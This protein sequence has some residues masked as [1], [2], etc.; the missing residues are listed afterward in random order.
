MLGYLQ[1]AAGL[2]ASVAAREETAT[3]LAEAERYLADLRLVQGER[4]AALERLRQA[5]EAA[6]RWRELGARLALLEAAQER[7]KQLGLRRELAASR[8]EVEEQE[9]RSQALG[10]QLVAAAAEAETAREALSTARAAAHAR[11]DALAALNAA[12][13][14]HAQAARYGEHLS[15]EAQTLACERAALP[16]TAPT[17]PAPDLDALHR[18]VQ[19]AREQAEHAEAQVR[20]LERQ[21]AQGREAERQRTQAQA[22]AEADRAALAREQGRVTQALATLAPEQEKMAERLQAATAERERVETLLTEAQ[23]Q[24]RAAQE[25]RGQAQAERTRLQ[26]GLAPLRRELE[27]LE[28]ALNAYARYGEGA[29]NALRLDHPGIVGSVADVLTVPA[30]LETAVTAALGR[31]LE[32]VVVGTAD[33]ARQIIQELKRQGG[34]ATFLPLELLRE[35][36]R[37][38]AALLSLPGVVGNLA[39]LCPTDPPLVGRSLLA[40][41]LIV[42]TLDTANRLALAYRQRPR[43]VTLGGEVLEASGAITGGVYAIPAAVFWPTNAAFRSWLKRWMRRRRLWTR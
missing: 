13:Q 41:T 9:A 18:S 31:R 38:D 27:R 28:A 7:E 36:P 35:R 34:R 5:A 42:D 29:R 40:D 26:A 22:R 21:L 14:A 4:L 2:S 6:R 16:D 37:R 32:Q 8:A 1:E 43:L 39:D 17:E 30:E 3:R 19:L 24:A 10:A 23:A 33:D 12:E 20:E 11:E 15:T 25:R